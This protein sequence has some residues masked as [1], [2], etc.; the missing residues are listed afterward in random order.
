[1]V[2][3]PQITEDHE[4]PDHKEIHSTGNKDLSKKGVKNTGKEGKGNES[5]P[6]KKPKKIFHFANLTSFEVKSCNIEHE[7]GKRDGNNLNTKQGVDHS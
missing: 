2:D 7:E 3:V 1:M 5:T 6:D 4:S